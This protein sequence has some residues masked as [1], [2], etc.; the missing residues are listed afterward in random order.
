MAGT[1]NRD[2]SGL[3]LDQQGDRNG[4]PCGQYGIGN[5]REVALDGYVPKMPLAKERQMTS[6]RLVSGIAVLMSITG[7]ASSIAYRADYVPDHAVVADERIAG[8]VL[9]YT[10]VADD[11]R[12]VTGGATSFTGSGA[13]LTTPIGMMTREIAVKVFSQVATE[14][15]TAAHELIDADRFAVVVRP[16]AKDFKYGFPQ[17]KNLGFAITPEVQVELKLTVLDASGRP[18]L[19]KDYASG[20]VEGKSYMMSGKPNER[21]SKLAHETIYAL[22]LSA[23]GDVR[24]FQQSTQGAAPTR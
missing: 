14:G 13:K 22:M 9:V 6:L 19:E 16:E 18:L 5:L 3:A 17:L 21:I 10:T 23:A 15:A 11:E 2:A 12:L 8:R 4:A 7:C 24:M 1:P 20:I